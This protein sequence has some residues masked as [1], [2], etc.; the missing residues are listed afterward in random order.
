MFVKKTVLVMS[1]MTEVSKQTERDGRL[2]ISAI[3]G[4]TCLAFPSLPFKSHHAGYPRS[5]PKPT[6]F[7]HSGRAKFARAMKVSKSG[8]KNQFAPEKGCR[9]W[10]CSNLT[11]IYILSDENLR[12]VLRITLLVFERHESLLLTP[13]ISNRY[14]L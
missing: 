5:G 4:V 7:S 11:L 6:A 3:L 9:I 12:H 1:L 10:R 2:I 14:A 8:R 13:D